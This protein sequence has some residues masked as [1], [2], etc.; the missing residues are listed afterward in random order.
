MRFRLVFLL[1]PATLHPIQRTT[2]NSFRALTLEIV[3]VKNSYIVKYVNWMAMLVTLCM[4]VCVHIIYNQ[5]YELIMSRCSDHV[6]FNTLLLLNYF[7]YFL[8]YSF[9]P[10]FSHQIM[11]L[12][13]Y[14]HLPFPK[15]IMKRQCRLVLGRLLNISL[16]VSSIYPDYFHSNWMLILVS[17]SFF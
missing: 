14:R 7:N 13:L 17:F 9:F 1:K 16:P 15:A 5:P 8:I 6:Y 11:G 2:S 3:K 4:Y 10:S 12:R